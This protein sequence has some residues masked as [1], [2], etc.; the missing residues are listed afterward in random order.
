[1]KKLLFCFAI[2]VLGIAHLNA[3]DVE[4][5]VKAGLN[6]ASIN[7]D[8]VPDS[9]I[10]TAFNFGVMAEIPVSSKLSFQP[11]L[12]YS[13]QGYATDKESIVFNYINVPLMAKYY[14]TERFSFQAGPQIGVLTSAKIEDIDVKDNLKSTDF[15]LNFGLGYKL[16]NGLNFNARYNLGLSNINDVSGMSN[17][18]Q[19]GVVQVSVG[20]FFF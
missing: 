11:E 12:L 20:Y 15:G 10:T 5:G 6:F 7:G 2:A 13:G 3:Q 9:G 8:G 19:N 16:D 17:K 18:N 1:M 4:F 14:V